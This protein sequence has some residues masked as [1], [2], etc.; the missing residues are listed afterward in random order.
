MSTIPYLRL[1]ATYLLFPVCQ[2]LQQL[3]GKA[4]M[5]VVSA[6]PYEA[7][8]R[9]WDGHNISQYVTLIAGQYVGQQRP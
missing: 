7:L 6:I 4:D 2:S 3:V 5:I 1:T 9:E 8:K